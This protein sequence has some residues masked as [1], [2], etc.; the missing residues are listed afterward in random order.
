MKALILA[1]GRGRRLWPFTAEHPK[2]LL[3]VGGMTLLERQLYHLNAAGVDQA[4]VVC[5]FGIEK[6]RAVVQSTQIGRTKLI[7]NPFYSVSDNLISL[8]VARIEMDA[9]FLLVNGD[10]IFHPGC[11]QSLLAQRSPCALL[12]SRKA[13]YAPDDMKLRI[14][15][16]RVQDIG[17]AL[18]CDR[19]DAES[20]GMLLFRG[21]GVTRLRAA[22]EEIVLSD[23]AMDSH[24][25]A[26]V[27][28]ML[29]RGLLLSACF[30][31]EFPCSDVDTPADLERVRSSFHRYIAPM[32]E[33]TRAGGRI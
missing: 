15:G 3:E 20:L 1:A 24:F 21:D 5:G 30:A 12:A 6:V 28:H 8:W 19:A 16:D 26:V 23:S 18:P 13:Q 25:P 14:D 2:C 4:V 10:N 9:D 27:Q 29:D 31:E 22:L 7:Y 17:K 11:V 32:L 33:A